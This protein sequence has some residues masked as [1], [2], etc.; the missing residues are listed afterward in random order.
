MSK[1]IIVTRH[2]SLVTYIKAKGIAPENTP[3]VS[4]VTGDDV[5]DKVSIPSEAGHLLQ[6]GMLKTQHFQY[7]TH[8]FFVTYQNYLQ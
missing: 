3:V 1:Y 8:S 5:R 7:L 2:P 4:H 6:E